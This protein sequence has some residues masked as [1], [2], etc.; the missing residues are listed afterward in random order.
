MV[1]KS[2]ITRITQDEPVRGPGAGQGAPDGEGVG[3]TAARVRAERIGSGDGRVYEISF[4][5]DDG[6]GGACS[7]SIRAGVPHNQGRSTTPR[8]RDRRFRHEP[9]NAGGGY[10]VGATCA[11]LCRP[12]DRGV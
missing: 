10:V 5:A 12:A 2:E 3:T 4:S 7:G 11:G 8:D 1:M 9:V 6:N